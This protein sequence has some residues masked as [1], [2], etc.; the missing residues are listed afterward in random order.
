MISTRSRAPDLLTVEVAA[1]LHD[2]LDK[3]Y[4]PPE[5][6]ADPY[7]Y[8]L[9]FFEKLCASVPALDL[10]ADGRAR[11]IARIIEN[12]SWTTEKKLR[13]EGAW[14]AWHESCTELHCVQDADRL[15][16]IGAF[17][18]LWLR[19]DNIT[20]DLAARIGIMRCAAFS[21]ATNR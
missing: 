15:D 20:I 9:P 19:T 18:M 4:V 11:D 13:A 2:V 7:A 16:A 21:A 8:F 6:S 10:I 3:K 17:G 12:V 5:A 1:L 14:S